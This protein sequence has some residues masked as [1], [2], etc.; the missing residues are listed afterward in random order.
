M[1]SVIDRCAQAAR[2]DDNSTNRS[3]LLT[4]E[5]VELCEVVAEAVAGHLHSDRVDV[6]LHSSLPK[7]LADRASVLTIVSNLLD[8]ALKYSSSDSVVRIESTITKMND[9]PGVT[10][11]II[12]AIGDQGAPDPGY[13]F[14]KYYRGPRSRNVSGTGLGL[15]LSRRLAQRMGVELSLSPAQ[16]TL[17][18]FELWLPSEV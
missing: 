15:Y 5:P 6:Q 3:T 4:I 16:K 8:N 18:E 7:C 12:N 11:R 2:V 13:I 10:L 1:R 14:E 17:V 9:R